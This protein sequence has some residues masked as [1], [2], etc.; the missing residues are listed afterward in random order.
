MCMDRKEEKGESDPSRDSWPDV[1]YKS[2]VA[3][4][5]ISRLVNPTRHAGT[6]KYSEDFKEY[7]AILTRDVLS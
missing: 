6:C 1:G 4:L 3:N 7:F 2:K 5:K